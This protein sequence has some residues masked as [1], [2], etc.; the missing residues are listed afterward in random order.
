MIIDIDCIA[1][2]LHLSKR[3]PSS[4]QRPFWGQMNF[5]FKRALTLPYLPYPLMKWDM[6]QWWIVGIQ[7]NLL[8]KYYLVNIFIN[9]KVHSISSY[10]PLWGKIFRRPKSCNSQ[11]SEPQ[12]KSTESSELPHG[13]STYPPGPC[14]P[15]RNKGLIRPYERQPMVNKPWS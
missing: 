4:W 5:R 12:G 14:A 8:N 13:W 3:I 1:P 2:N 7:F 15:H 9:T 11:P 6:K 10:H